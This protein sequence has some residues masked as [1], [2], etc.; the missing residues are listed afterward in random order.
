MLD[1]ASAP[2]L[3]AAAAEAGNFGALAASV[4]GGITSN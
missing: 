3:L 2:E 4:L 1:A